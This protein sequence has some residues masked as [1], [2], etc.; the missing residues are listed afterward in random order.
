MKELGHYPIESHLTPV[1]AHTFSKEGE[2]WRAVVRSKNQ[3]GN[4]RVRLYL[5]RNDN[6]KGWVTVHK[7]NVQ[8]SR[9]DKEKKTVKKYLNASPDSN[10]PY[11]PVQHY[12]VV[13][14]ETIEKTNDW[15]TAIVQYE[16][17]WSST[18]KT[19]LY[20][21]QIEEGD[22]KGTGY[23]WNINSDTWPE[24]RLVANSFLESL[25]DN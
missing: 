22:A 10:A 16:D 19:R 20:M 8:S 9:W 6:Q 4:E 3:Y 13:G 11:F 24:E 17:D 2:W 15:W 5:W 21:W 23:K 25:D 14:G 1:D 18:H 12:D 7:W